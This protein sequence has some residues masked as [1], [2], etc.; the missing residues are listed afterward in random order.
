MPPVEL[1]LAFGRDRI[2]FLVSH[3]TLARAALVTLQLVAA[4]EGPILLY[5]RSEDD[6]PGF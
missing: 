4:L 5:L 2:E 1:L 6:E 3:T